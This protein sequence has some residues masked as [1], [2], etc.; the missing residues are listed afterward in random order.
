MIFLLLAVLSLCACAAVAALGLAGFDA[1]GGFASLEFG[2]DGSIVSL[3]EN[4][5]GRELVATPCPLVVA[6][7]R[8]GRRR[9]VTDEVELSVERFH[10]GWTFRIVSADIKDA[11]TVEFCRLCPVC[12]THVGRLVNGL[13]D[14]RS[15]VVLRAYDVETRMCLSSKAVWLEMRGDENL[16]GRRFGLSRM[17]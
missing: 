7:G 14:D 6:V 5:S 10:G 17:L 15:G 11:V 16:V 3:R 9:A 1:D 8:D 13:S 2:K 12:T 4:A